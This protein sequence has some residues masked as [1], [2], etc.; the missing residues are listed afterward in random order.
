MRAPPPLA[1]LSFIQ[2]SCAQLPPT[3]TSLSSP[4]CPRFSRWRLPDLDPK[5]SS[6]PLSL[7][8]PLSLSLPLPFLLPCAS[9]VAPSRAPPQPRRAPLCGSPAP[10]RPRMPGPAPGGLAPRGLAP[11]VPAPQRPCPP[12]PRALAAVPFPPARRRVPTWPRHGLARSRARVR[13]CAMFSF[14]FIQF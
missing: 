6:P 2:F 14:W 3:L 11:R 9:P 12:Q 4:L 1:S 5:V 13:G 8:L 10:R 7:P